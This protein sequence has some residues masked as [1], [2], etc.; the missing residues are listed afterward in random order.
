MRVLFLLTAALTV[1]CAAAAWADLPPGTDVSI[2]FAGYGVTTTYVNQSGNDIV[3]T[4]SV[5]GPSKAFLGHLMAT[6]ASGIVPIPPAA[7]ADYT[8]KLDLAYVGGSFNLATREAAYTG[9]WKLYNP[10]AGVNLPNYSE[11]ANMTLKLTYNSIYTSGAWDGKWVM[12]NAG[13][14]GSNWT[15]VNPLTVV[16][17]TWDKANTA[18][19]TPFY[20]EPFVNMHAHGAVP[21]AGSVA[22][23]LMGLSSIVGFR[24]LR[25]G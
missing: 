13:A 15:L 9:I 19:G 7:L 8:F 3:N 12:D 2:G 17:G 20:G 22:L 24:R 4:L 16:N 6:P 10:T 25:T 21:E 23:A 18:S 5:D 11:L 14:R 1:L